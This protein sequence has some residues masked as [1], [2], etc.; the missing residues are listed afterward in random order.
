MGLLSCFL[1][2][3]DTQGGGGILPSAWLLECG[4]AAS[5]AALMPPPPPPNTPAFPLKC[6]AQSSSVSSQEREAREEH[7]K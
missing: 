6:R 7:W 2:A 1:L 3:R 5:P 4:S